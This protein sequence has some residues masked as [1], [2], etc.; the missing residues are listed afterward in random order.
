[1]WFRR[2]LEITTQSHIAADNKSPDH[3]EWCITA[4]IIVIGVKGG[5]HLQRRRYTRSPTPRC[6]DCFHVFR[7]RIIRL[8]GTRNSTACRQTFSFFCATIRVRHVWICYVHHVIKC[9]SLVLLAICTLGPPP[10]FFAFVLSSRKNKKIIFCS[11][12]V[13]AQVIANLSETLSP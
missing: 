8:G 10:C 12:Q 6:L 3:N 4:L 5:V 1:M 2:R 13:A 11:D 9:F 7:T